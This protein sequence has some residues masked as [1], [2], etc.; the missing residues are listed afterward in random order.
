[1]EHRSWSNGIFVQNA[2]PQNAFPLVG[3]VEK[4]D[5]GPHLERFLDN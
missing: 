3:N 4:D 2:P 5:V 1:M